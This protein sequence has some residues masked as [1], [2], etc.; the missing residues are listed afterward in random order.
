MRC[1]P[2][3][4]S[5]RWRSFYLTYLSICFAFRFTLSTYL[6]YLSIHSMCVCHKKTATPSYLYTSRS[7]YL[8]YITYRSVDR[9]TYP[10]IYIHI[11]YIIPYL[12]SIFPSCLCIYLLYLYSLSTL[13]IFRF[14][15]DG[16][17]GGM[18]WVGGCMYVCM[19]GWLVSWLV[20]WLLTGW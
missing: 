4:G 9:S 3:E 14:H 19:R 20:G 2:L 5:L 8:I 10:S 15:R 1:L 13:S 18:V 6:S 11:Y 16:G 7:V 17:A 12:L